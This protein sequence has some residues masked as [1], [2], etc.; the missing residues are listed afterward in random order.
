MK[1]LLKEYG[2]IILAI[3][4]LVFVIWSMLFGGIEVLISTFTVNQAFGALLII[5]FT[6]LSL[7]VRKLIHSAK[8]WKSSDTWRKNIKV[9]DAAYL[10]SSHN[11]HEVEIVDFDD[12]YTIVKLKVHKSQIYKPYN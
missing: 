1:K 10:S 12:E 8:W 2:V 11:G 3:L 6:I 9:G 7:F 4:T 5:L